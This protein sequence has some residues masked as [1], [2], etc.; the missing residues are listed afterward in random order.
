MGFY[1]FSQSESGLIFDVRE[2]MRNQ[3]RGQMIG[4]AQHVLHPS[5]INAKLEDAQGWPFELIL[6]GQGWATNTGEEMDLVCALLRE[7]YAGEQNPFSPY[8][9]ARP[10]A[11]YDFINLA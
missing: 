6:V 2:I 7:H 10:I 3:L 1:R 8:P 5:A 4:L 9:E 11:D